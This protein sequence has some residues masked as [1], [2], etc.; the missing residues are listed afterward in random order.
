[1]YR[2]VERNYKDIRL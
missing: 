2:I 1:M